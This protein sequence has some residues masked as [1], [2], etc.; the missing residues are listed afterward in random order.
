[1]ENLIFGCEDSLKFLQS[2]ISITAVVDRSVWDL[3]RGLIADLLGNVLVYLVDAGESLKSLASFQNLVEAVLSAGFN[4]S[5][6]LVGIG[7]GTVTDVV[8]F[9]AATLFRGVSSIL[10]PTTL[11][12]QV[13]GSIGGKGALN[14][15]Q[16]KNCIGSIHF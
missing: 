1:M 11:L 2:R 6:M 9:M 5:G 8:S 12:A 14:A 13:D 10:V 3:H 4:K 7:G 15:L 16:I